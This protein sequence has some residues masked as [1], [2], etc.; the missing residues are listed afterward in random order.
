MKVR[1]GML[2]TD[3]VGKAG[4]QFIQRTRFGNVLR[5]ITVPVQRLASLQNPQRVVNS[6]LFTRWSLL[7]PDIRAMW[8]VIGSNLITK[9]PFGDDVEMSGRDAFTSCSSLVYPLTYSIVHANAFSYVRPFTNFESVS[10]S[11][12]GGE[13]EFLDID[14][15]NVDFYQVKGAILKNGAIN[16]GLDKLKTFYRDST[17]SNSGTIYDYFVNRIGYAETGKYVQLAI[18][19]ISFSGLASEWQMFKV[20]VQ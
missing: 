1:F 15:R 2:M 5:N 20:R 8:D 13:I 12:S 6:F 19:G 7:N 18:R 4:G 14:F 16:L 3:A 17:V 10:F 9:N 11:N